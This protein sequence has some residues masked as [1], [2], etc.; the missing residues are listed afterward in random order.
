M[1]LKS[2]LN[3]SIC[4]F[5][6]VIV[7]SLG[8][9]IHS[10][11]CRIL[12]GNS[13]ENDRRDE[14]MLFSNG[15]VYIGAFKGM[16]PHGKGK[17]FWSE[18]TIYD[19]DWL[20]GKMSGKGKILWPSQ[21]T[22][23]GDFSAGY[24]NGFGILTRPDGAVYRGSWKTNSQHG[25][26]RKMYPNSDSYDGCWREGV[27]EGSGR[28][29]WSD[30]N[31]YIGN[32]KNGKMSGRGVM[33]LSSNGDFF[34]GFWSNGLRHG[35]GFCRFSDGSYYFG[36][37]SKGLKDGPG[38]LYPAGSKHIGK[39]KLEGH[40]E[41][42]ERQLSGYFSSQSEE[43]SLR[44]V[45][46]TLSDKISSSFRKGSP[47]SASMSFH[48]DGET[49]LLSDDDKSV[50]Y[51]REYIQGV[52]IRERAVNYSKRSHRKL[53]FAKDVKTRRFSG[54]MFADLRRHYLMLSLQ[55]GIRHTVGKITPIPKREV[56]SS[57]FSENARLKIGFPRQGSRSTPSHSSVDFEWKDYCPMVFRNLREL[58]KLN[59]AE[60]IMS[61]C[62]VDGLQELSSP[63]KSG[64]LFYLSHDGRFVIKTL[65]KSELKALL[66]MLPHYYDHVKAY[67]NTLITKFFGAHRIVLRHGKKVRFV[68]M[69][70]MFCTELHIHRRYDLKGSSQ[71]RFT[72]EDRIDESTTLKDLDLRY[73]FHMDVLLR[74][75]LFRYIYSP[76][77]LALSQH[78]GL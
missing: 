13:M 7:Y 5:I 60:Y 42:R 73:E 69:G 76:C 16:I 70:N 59:A 74:E 49:E 14:E 4:L 68:V 29:A 34:D 41:R 36:T 15:D 30:G 78:S 11:S 54:M 55:L 20:E 67:E 43:G 12:I 27:R 24:F 2:L 77:R 65:K 47:K 45:R 62:G 1:G 50:A 71:G 22:Y 52:L 72:D 28:Y 10:I 63:G 44:G 64:S 46:R 6:S 53:K 18:G 31:T 25:I 39:L 66:K 23:E 75:S 21:C 17:Y 51:E 38:T 32:W 35:S 40:V 26:G 58:F 57:D 9:L 3:S 33:K 19:G 48:D 8:L 37:W 61:I 56:R